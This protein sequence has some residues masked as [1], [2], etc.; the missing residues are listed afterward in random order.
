MSLEALFGTASTIIWWQEIARALLVFA[1]GLALVRLA[2]RRVFGR[3]AALDI[4]VSIVIGSSLS[5]AMTG[6]APLW[7][8]MAASA[9]LMGVHWL[10]AQAVTRSSPMSRFLEGKAVRLAPGGVLDE[11][12]RRHHSVSDADLAEALREA[13]VERLED[14][15]DLV[16]EP[17]GKLIAIRRQP[18]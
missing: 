11:R 6:N 18:V 8:T 3:W 10:L 16:L 5:R 1:Y 14:I 17:S 2:G 4:I 7:G 13:G 9:A 15:R 12:R